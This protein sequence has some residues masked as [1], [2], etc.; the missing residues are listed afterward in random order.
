[1]SRMLNTV[2]WVVGTWPRVDLRAWGPGFL[3]RS[4][5]VFAQYL[6]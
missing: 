4:Q 6:G 3:R 2:E 5:E 1:M